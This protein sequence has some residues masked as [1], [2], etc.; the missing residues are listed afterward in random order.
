[1]KPLI[2]ISIV[3]LLMSAC[4]AS[5]NNNTESSPETEV[6][7]TLVTTDVA[8]DSSEVDTLTEMDDETTIDV[9][10]LM[11]KFNTVFDLPLKID[12]A[13][14]T[15]FSSESAEDP[16]TLTGSEVAYLLRKMTTDQATSSADYMPKE[17][18]K[19]DSIKKNGN[20]KEYQDNLDLGMTRYSHA[21]PVG[22][23]IW[24]EQLTIYLWSLDYA[25]YEACP[26]AAGTYVFGTVFY[27]G[28]ARNTTLLGEDSG[29]GDP[30]VWGR[31][32][33]EGLLTELGLSVDH[34]NTYGE[35]DYESGEEIITKNEEYSEFEITPNGFELVPDGI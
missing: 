25:T 21:K 30:P 31:T 2:Y 20:Y 15:Q 32:L 18:I 8:S 28:K 23:V 3:M 7:D 34:S 35:E 1:M 14:V 19:L 16:Y 10:A 13:F 4:G 6:A 5:D 24:D 33:T 17:F 26:Y 9:T 11:T 27:Q 29:G 12:S 22:K